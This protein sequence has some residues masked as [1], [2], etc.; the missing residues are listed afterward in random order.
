[1]PIVRCDIPEGHD[2]ATKDALYAIL[3]QAI[4][5]N[6]AKEHIWISLNEKYSPEGN[7]Q[8][9]MT[10]DL[11]PGRGGDS[12]RLAATFDQVQAAFHPLIGTR[13]DDLIV[14]VRTFGDADCLSGG[15]PLP[16]LESLTPAL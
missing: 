3:H 2:R 6:W 16:P 7:A 9:I 5:D 11:R 15:G 10:I 13:A 4:A 8:V 1:M 14:V 12:E